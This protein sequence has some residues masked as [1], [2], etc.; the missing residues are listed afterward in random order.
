MSSDSIE[1]FPHAEYEKIKEQLKISRGI[2]QETIDKQ[3]AKNIINEFNK[4]CLNI[5]YSTISFKNEIDFRTMSYTAREE[6]AK[7]FRSA[8]YGVDDDYG[9][10]IIIN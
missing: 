2:N 3:C 5:D 10:K 1:I 4:Y 8:G 6:L 7:K 9:Y